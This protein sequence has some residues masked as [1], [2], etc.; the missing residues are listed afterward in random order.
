MSYLIAILGKKS[1]SGRFFAIINLM[2]ISFVIPAYNEENYLGN[3]LSA[4]FDKLKKHPDVK[5]EVVVINNASTDNTK[6]VAQSFSGVKV[7]DEPHKG[8]THARQAGLNAA[9]G[10]L[11]AFIDADSMVSENWL[12]MMLKEFEADPKLI[13]LSGPY[14]YYDLPGE[15]AKKGIQVWYHLAYV[16]SRM[17]KY[18]VNGGNFVV[19]KSALLEVG[20]FDTS[21]K[22]YGEDTDIARRLAKAGKVKF[23]KKFFV[24]SSARRLNDEGVMATAFKYGVNYVSEITLKKPLTKNYKDIR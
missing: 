17:I 1:L 7:V 12:S 6:K 13:C 23:N 5:A 10:E 22:F 3:C 4:I 9:T 14:S 24:Y 15:H 21:I 20:G 11:L 2:T 16:I 19:K 8:L 18:T